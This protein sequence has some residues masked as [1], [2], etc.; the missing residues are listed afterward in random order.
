MTKISMII[1]YKKQNVPSL[2]KQL[3]EMRIFEQKNRVTDKLYQL[4]YLLWQ[5]RIIMMQFSL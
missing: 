4:L 3:L 5:G 1:T 2:T